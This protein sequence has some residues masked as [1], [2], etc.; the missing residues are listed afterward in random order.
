MALLAP[1]GH[2]LVFSPFDLQHEGGQRGHEAEE[3]GAL[4]GAAL[5]G[6]LAAVELGHH[7]VTLLLAVLADLLRQRQLG[8][9]R[10]QLVEP[11]P[12]LRILIITCFCR[13]LSSE[14]GHFLQLL[15]QFLVDLIDL[16][17]CARVSGGQAKISDKD[18]PRILMITFGTLIILALEVL[19]HVLAKAFQLLRISIHFT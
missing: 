5:A 1:L 13:K 8:T 17:H 6:V 15:V 10:Q 7:L 12:N 4:H 16:H 14:G 11:Q 9:C 19:S 2:C 3:A 18:K